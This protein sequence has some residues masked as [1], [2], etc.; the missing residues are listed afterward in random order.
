MKNAIALLVGLKRVD[1]NAPDYTSLDDPERR[2]GI[3]GSEL[4]A[5]N[6]ERL[7][8]DH[9]GFVIYKLLNEKATSRSILENID[10]AA[11]S[12]NAGD[13]FFFFFSGHG[14]QIKDDNG[15]EIDHKDE[16]LAA[17]DRRII[18]DELPPRWARFRP[19]VRILM[20]SDTCN[21]GTIFRGQAPRIAGLALEAPLQI[22]ASLIHM[23]ATHDSTDTPGE[24][25]GSAFTNALLK[26]WNHGS[27]QGDYE[28][29]LSQTEKIK[30][31]PVLSKEGPDVAMFVGE[32]PFT[33]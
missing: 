30:S 12:L 25:T 29:F 17:Y 9:G 4:D 24:P 2:D 21:S 1:P 19:G 26:V 10:L 8:L 27:Y 5:T 7:L 20:I 32:R 14:D 6:M 13:L 31:G 28:E 15:D 23:A 16:A 18:D 11:S 33:V 3:R 22:K